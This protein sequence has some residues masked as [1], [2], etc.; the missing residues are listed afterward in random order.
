MASTPNVLNTAVPRLT[1]DQDSMSGPQCQG[2]KRSHK[3]KGHT[4]T[5]KKFPEQFEGTTQQ[6]KGF[7]E[8]TPTSYR[9]ISG[10]KSRKGQKRVSLL[11]PWG[12]K[13]PERVR[14]ESKA[15]QQGVILSHAC[16]FRIVRQKHCQRR[17]FLNL[18]FRLVLDF[19]DFLAPGPAGASFFFFLRP[20][21]PGEKRHTNINFLL[22]LTSRWPWDKRLVVPGLT[23]PKSLCV[24]ASKHRKCKLL[25]LVN[26]RPGLSRLSKSLCVQSLCAFFLP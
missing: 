11:R 7:A 23:G 22:W 15:S 6:N 1:S 20:E 3:R 18:L 4:D 10:P 21:G 5:S 19:L 13:S 24:F 2:L 26:R 8:K 25:P 14:K 12:P 16:R 17:P 9:A